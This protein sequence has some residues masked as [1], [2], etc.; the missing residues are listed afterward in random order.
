MEPSGGLD[1]DRQEALALIVFLA[2]LRRGFDFNNWNAG[3]LGKTSNGS[4]KIHVFVV[5]DKSQHSA[6]RAA[7]EAVE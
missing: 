7:S 4:G 2:V 3:A 6:S 1:M 5:H